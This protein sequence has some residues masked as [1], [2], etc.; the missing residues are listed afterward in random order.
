MLGGFKDSL[1][2]DLTTLSGER[3]LTSSSN[4]LAEEFHEA[5]KLLESHRIQV[6]PFITHRFSLSQIEEAFR[7]ASNKSEYDAIKVVILP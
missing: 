1:E 3:V 5:I 7:V 4:N 6:K 2:I